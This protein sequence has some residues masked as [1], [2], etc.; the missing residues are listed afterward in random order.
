LRRPSRNVVARGRGRL[1][2]GEGGW[3]GCTKGG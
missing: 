1:D 3:R 2:D